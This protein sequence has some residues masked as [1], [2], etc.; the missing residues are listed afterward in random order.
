M[1]VLDGSVYSLCKK[2]ASYTN[3]NELKDLS[4]TF[5]QSLRKLCLKK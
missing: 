5:A 2:I 1:A 4:L 3:L